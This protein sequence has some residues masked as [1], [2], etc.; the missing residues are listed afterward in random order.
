MQR[1]GRRQDDRAFLRPKYTLTDRLQVPSAHTLVTTK[2]SLASLLLKSATIAD[3]E[4][5][6]H[7]ATEFDG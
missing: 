3:S 7:D 6:A 2:S 5:K 4:G 1:L